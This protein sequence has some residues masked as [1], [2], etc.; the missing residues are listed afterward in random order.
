[1]RGQHDL[2]RAAG[3]AKLD[4]S[5]VRFAPDRLQPTALAPVLA[6]VVDDV[7]ASLRCA[8]RLAGARAATYELIST[9]C[10]GLGV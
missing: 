6:G 8:V 1:M 2:A 3:H 10:R 9:H 7:S 4:L 5:P